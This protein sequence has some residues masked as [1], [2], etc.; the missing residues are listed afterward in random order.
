MYTEPLCK[1]EDILE[2]DIIDISHNSYDHLDNYSLSTLCKRARAPHIFATLDDEKH[3]QSVRISGLD[4]GVHDAISPV[5]GWSLKLN[6]ED[7]KVYLMVI[8][9][10]DLFHDEGDE[11]ERLVCPDFEEIGLGERFGSF[12]LAMIHIYR[13]I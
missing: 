3:F 7:K 6:D 4:G 9:A 2:E 8:L 1:I 5:D 10:T 12:D 11:A 13:E